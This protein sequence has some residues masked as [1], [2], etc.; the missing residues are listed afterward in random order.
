ML[1]LFTNLDAEESFARR[2]S[3]SGETG[4]T[5]VFRQVRDVQKSKGSWSRRVVVLVRYE[6]RL[7]WFA[8]SDAF[9]W[10]ALPF[11]CFEAA[12]NR[13]G[14]GWGLRPTNAERGHDTPRACRDELKYRLFEDPVKPMAAWDWAVGQPKASHARYRSGPGVDVRRELQIFAGK[15][16]EIPWF[17]P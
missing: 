17:R 5:R 16:T 1:D 15:S 4:W 3:M 9:S 13:Y 8:R 11:Q 6:L 14:C 2:R 12:V 7:P 10:D